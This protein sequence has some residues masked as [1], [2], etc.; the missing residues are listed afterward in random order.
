LIDLAT[1]EDIGPQS[2]NYQDNGFQ[3]VV[4]PAD[5]RAEILSSKTSHAVIYGSEEGTQDQAPRSPDPNQK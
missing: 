2:D 3:L 5:S 4:S 1:G